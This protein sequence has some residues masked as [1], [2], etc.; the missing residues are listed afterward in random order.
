MCIG[1]CLQFCSRTSSCSSQTLSVSRHFQRSS[2]CPE[3]PHL[4]PALPRHA[5]SMLHGHLIACRGEGNL[6][7]HDRL[8]YTCDLV[9]LYDLDFFCQD[10]LYCT[11]CLCV[12]RCVLLVSVARRRIC[13]MSAC[14]SLLSGCGCAW[15]VDVTI[16]QSNRGLCQ[17]TGAAIH[18]PRIRMDRRHKHLTLVT[19]LVP[20]YDRRRCKQFTAAKRPPKE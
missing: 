5:R 17:C 11:W 4:P 1:A 19:S 9:A 16:G 2:K 12:H 3:V 8:E 10:M 13:M 6:A 14:F 18:S 20:V 7:G 15:L